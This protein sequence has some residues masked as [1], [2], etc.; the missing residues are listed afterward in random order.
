MRKGMII[1]TNLLLQILAEK[2]LNFIGKFSDKS[3]NWQ[4]RSG[5]F[6]GDQTT[7]RQLHRNGRLWQ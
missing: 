4:Q 5:K 3:G 2:L 1:R 6:M 7:T